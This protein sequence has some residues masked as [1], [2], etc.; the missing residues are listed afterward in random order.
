MDLF[1]TPLRILVLL[2]VVGLA[3][4]F[5]NPT[6][7]QDDKKTIKIKNTTKFTVDEIHISPDE[8]DHWGDDILDDDELLK[9]GET[10][11][12]EVDCGK[13]DVKLIA[14]D[15]S[16]CEIENITL[17]EADQWNIVADCPH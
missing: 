10:V 12:V 3:T 11:E 1:Y 13:W 14:E 9:P 15:A 5:T 8:E 16:A 7:R 4:A 2:T 6:V 17:C